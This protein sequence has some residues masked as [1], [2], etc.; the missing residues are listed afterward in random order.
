MD[1][2]DNIYKCH[3]TRRRC[4]TQHLT[5]FVSVSIEDSESTDMECLR[6]PRGAEAKGLKHGEGGGG[7]E[8]RV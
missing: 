1:T 6:T 8:Y 4:H 5:L 7:G 3:A 2:L